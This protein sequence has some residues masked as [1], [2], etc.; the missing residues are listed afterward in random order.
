MFSVNRN[1]GRFP[2]PEIVEQVRQSVT[3]PRVSCT[4]LSARCA[5][6]VPSTQPSHLG[7]LPAAGLTRSCC[8][9]SLLLTFG[10]ADVVPPHA[11]HLAFIATNA[12][13]AMCGQS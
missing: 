9:G 11:K 1:D 6:S 8:A 3:A 13:A 10:P 12:P 5:A 7:T 2:R 4:E